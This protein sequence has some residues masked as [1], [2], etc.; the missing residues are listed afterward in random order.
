M[1]ENIEL[2]FFDTFS[3]ESSEELNLDLVQFPKPVFI[4]EVRIIP[5]GARVQADFPGGVRL[6]ATNPSQFEIEFFVND[7][8]KPGASTFE[9]LGEL[10]YKQNGT[11][12]LACERRASTV[13]NVLKLCN[14]EVLTLF[15]TGWYTTITLAVYGALTKGLAEQLASTAPPATSAAVEPLVRSPGHPEWQG[16]SADPLY[17]SEQQVEHYP[18]SY[19]AENAYPQQEYPPSYPDQWNSSQVRSRGELSVLHSKINANKA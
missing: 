5:L 9:S 13:S 10:E 14:W 15:L 2:L 4:S 17:P 11:I 1:A 8:S 19:Q 7:L 6:G 18:G 12:H 3:H 16:E